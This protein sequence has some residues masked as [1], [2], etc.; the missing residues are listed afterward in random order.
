MN[1]EVNH[2]ERAHAE[3]SPSALKY[4]AKCPGFHGRDTTNAAAEMGTRIHE[5]LEVRDPSALT[6]EEELA[7]YDQLLADEEEVFN[8]L[9]PDGADV[10][11]RELRL[12]LKL[13]A[14]TPTFGTCDIVA[15]SRDGETAL[16]A[17]YKT[18]ISRIDDVRDNWQAKAYTLG[19]FQRWP[20]VKTIHF[21][22]LVPRVHGV[23]L[24]TFHSP[25]DHAVL[26]NEIS[27]VVRAAEKTRPKWA[28]SSI[29]IDD[30]N[31]SVH[32]RF[33]RHEERCPGLGAVAI[34]IASRLEPG[35]LPEGPIRSSEV[36]DPA[37]LATLYRVSRIVESWASAIKFKALSAA[38]GGTNLPGLTLKSMGT[39][40]NI[41]DNVNACNIATQ[42]FGLDFE[43]VL[44]TASL[45]LGKLA[46]AVGA[47]APRGQKGRMADEFRERAI[48]LGVAVEGK[49][50]YTLVS[51]DDDSPES[52]TETEETKP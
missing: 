31:P 50:R 26:H 40:F 6:T 36:E 3:F 23:L 13:T 33:C 39:P 2:A 29:D 48:E 37:T 11:Y 32:C 1:P 27:A 49:A 20:E 35:L 38:L 9:F 47:A 43:E 15:I 46:K 52:D 5:A 16:V 42:E 34:S 12:T 8:Q 30:V 14:N 4:L 17:D 7:I 21:A 24:G 28:D 18:G 51:S 25:E 45:S 19:V 10:V 41:D 44:K 22:F